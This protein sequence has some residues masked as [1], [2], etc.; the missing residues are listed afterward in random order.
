MPVI[1]NMM[2]S[3][4]TISE[5]AERARKAAEITSDALSLS[6]T[7]SDALSATAVVTADPI[8]RSANGIRAIRFAMVFTT[9]YIATPV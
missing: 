8:P 7:L 5:I 4:I 9:P 2:L 1:P 6:L 3:A